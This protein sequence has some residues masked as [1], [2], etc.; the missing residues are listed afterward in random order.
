MPKLFNILVAAISL[1]NAVLFATLGYQYVELGYGL[2]P[3]IAAVLV[4][5]AIWATFH[6]IALVLEQTIAEQESAFMKE[7]NELRAQRVAELQAL[8]S[9]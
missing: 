2:H 3:C 7:V 8:R 1:L 9:K 6:F 5:V 4:L